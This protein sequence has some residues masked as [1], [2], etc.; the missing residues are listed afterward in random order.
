MKQGLFFWRR[1]NS[2]P[3]FAPSAYRQ[4]ADNSF[5]RHRKPEV[6]SI[7]HSCFSIFIW[8]ILH[9]ISN[10]SFFIL[11]L[12]SGDVCHIT[13]ILWWPSHRFLQPAGM[14]LKK[15]LPVHHIVWPQISGLQS[16]G[17]AAQIS[18]NVQL[19]TRHIP[20]LRPAAILSAEGCCLRVFSFLLL[21]ATV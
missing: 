14:P 7:I 1:I 9:L 10:S 17:W 4:A 16:A 2:E 3:F 21:K 8:I 13:V 19:P 5:I 20:C 18:P 11:I 6:N 15:C 12:P